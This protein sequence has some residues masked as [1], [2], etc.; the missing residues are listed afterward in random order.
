MV[1][2]TLHAGAHAGDAPEPASGAIASLDAPVPTT[3]LRGGQVS[4]TGDN[5]TSGQ[6]VKLCA[7]VDSK[8]ENPLNAPLA[9]LSK[10]SLK[11]TVPPDLKPGTYRVGIALA[12]KPPSTFTSSPIE[13]TRATPTISAL[14][15]ATLYPSGF[16]AADYTDLTIQGTG[17]AVASAG[18]PQQKDA[19]GNTPY[20]EK[21]QILINDVP[22]DTCGASKTSTPYCSKSFSVNGNDTRTLTVSGIPRTLA[23]KVNIS[24]KVGNAVSTSKEL[25]LSGSPR[26]APRLIATAILVAIL[27]LAWR[28]AAKKVDVPLTS[29]TARIRQWKTIFI[30]FDSNTYS[31]SRLQLVIWTFVALFGWI[32]LSVARSLIQSMVTFS[33]IPS[34]LPGV[35]F[36]SVGTSIAATGVASL[37][38]GKS[39]GPFSPSFSDFYSVGGIIAPE[40]A[41]FFLW[42]LVGA[43]G[44]IAF[45]LALD[46]A[47]IQNLPTLPDGFLQLAGI[48][49]FGYVGGKVVRKTGPI[50]KGVRAVK[51]QNTPTTVTW[52]LTGSGLAQNASFAYKTGTGAAAPTE[53]AFSDATV[54][55]DDADQ[56]GDATLFKKLTVT[57]T[58]TPDEAAPP[59]QPTGGTPVQGENTTHP[60]R[61]FVVI[62]PDGQ[63]AEWPY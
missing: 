56:D 53:K 16:N 35:L 1:F 58:N 54:Q 8:C 39:S 44:F 52:T 46:P 34:G 32:Y 19:F 60:V 18:D 14:S 30:D 11:F 49:A 61:L 13:V 42:T 20:D 2:A 6:Q 12:G 9:E 10:K 7:D 55:A 43:A 51:D 50:L 48:S 21:N 37:K 62:N 27:L 38:G 15:D 41:Q 3:V 40:R 47:T 31:L 22:L 17:F 28:A 5:L 63:Q 29:P 25:L 57:T 26:Y 33:D 24:V 4:V 23:G 45:T 59:D 36:V